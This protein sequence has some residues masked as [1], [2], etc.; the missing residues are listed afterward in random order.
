MF[1]WMF[2]LA[3]EEATPNWDLL[4]PY[5][6]VEPAA[7]APAAMAGALDAAEQDLAAALADS[8]PS[9]ESSESEFDNP[10]GPNAATPEVEEELE[11]EAETEEEAVDVPPAEPTGSP[12]PFGLPTSA[13]WGVRLLGTI[14]QAQPPRAALGLPDGQEVVVAP[15]SML[16]TVGMV[17]ISVGQDTIQLARVTPAGDHAEVEMVNLVAQYARTA[18]GD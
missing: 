8:T 14:A 15:G 7:A 6:A 13:G 17:V 1:W 3:C 16:P 18:G 4:S 5:G 9:E 10:F 12:D 2:A 11:E